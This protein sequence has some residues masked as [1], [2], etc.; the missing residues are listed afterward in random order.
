[1][2]EAL[3]LQVLF[4]KLDK[5]YKKEDI[6]KFNIKHRTCPFCKK[7][8]GI[9]HIKIKDGSELVYCPSCESIHKTLR[10]SK[11]H[12]IKTY[13]KGRAFEYQVKKLLENQGYIVFRCASSKPLDLVA[14][15]MGKVLVCECKTGFV[16]EKDK[17]KLGEWSVKLG[18]PMALFTKD[19]GNVQVE[20]FEPSER[21]EWRNTYQLLDDFLHFLLDNYSQ[22]FGNG[23]GWVN[24]SQLDSSKTIWKFLFSTE[25]QGF[26]GDK[27]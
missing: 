8:L 1:M 4:E 25:N 11:A 19:N 22:D 21:R 3:A 2:N 15:K 20:V 10:F 12:K 7:W 24:L 6:E 23:D 5:E 18:F 26:E 13:A 16:S 9:F 17:E 14:F 27:Q